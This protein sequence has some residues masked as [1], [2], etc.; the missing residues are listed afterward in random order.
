[1][2]RSRSAEVA[3]SPESRSPTSQAV[4]RAVK[5]ASLGNAMEWFDFGIYAYLAVTIGQVFFPVRERH[6]PAAVL[7]RDLRGRLPRPAARR[8]V[9]RAARRPDRPQE[10][11][12]PHHDHD[13]GRHLRHRPHPVATHR[14]ASGRPPCSILFRHVQGFSTGG[15]Y[16]GASTFIAEYAPD[17]RRGFFGSFLEFGTLAGYVGAAGLVTVICT[18]SSPTP[19]WSPGAGASRSSSPARSASSA[20]TCGCGS[21]RPRPSRSWSGARGA[22][23][24]ADERTRRDLARSSG[25]TGRA[26]PV[27]RPGRRVQHHRLHAAV[28]HADVPLDHARLQRDPRPSS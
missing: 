1:M 22:S 12:R 23:D 20:S 25:S 5:A 11:P 13:G 3:E 6:R 21:T 15:E 10:G 27:H 19:R 2:T 7:V 8:H 28:V 16:G 9:L 17:K 18:V 24:G 4:K 26:D 14:S